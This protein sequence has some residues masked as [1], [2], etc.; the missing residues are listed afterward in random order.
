MLALSI[1]AVSKHSSL[2]AFCLHFSLH[3]SLHS[4]KLCSGLCIL[5]VLSRPAQYLSVFS[6]S[7]RRKS[8]IPWLPMLMALSAV[9]HHRDSDAQHHGDSAGT[10]SAAWLAGLE[11]EPA[12]S[13]FP[14]G[15][16]ADSCHWLP[17]S[18]KIYLTFDSDFQQS[19]DMFTDIFT[20]SAWLLL[21]CHINSSLT[22]IRL[23]SFLAYFCPQAFSL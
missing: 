1:L 18:S 9:H 16:P 17:I 22:R 15:G 7:P 12:C 23:Y 19:S 3:L 13:W 14:V 4:S 11:I 20:T 8:R 2:L 6:G 21:C 10:Q 5:P